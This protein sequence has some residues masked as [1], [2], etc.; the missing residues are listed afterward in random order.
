MKRFIEGEDRSQVT[1]LPECLDDYIGEDNPVRVI[2]AFVDEL[3]LQTLGFEGAEPAA[4][5]RP[6]YHPAVLLKIY[7][8]GYLNRIQSSR[9][10]EREAQRNV[11]LMWL[12]GRLAPDFKTIADFRH[13][14]GKGIRNVC[15]RFVELCR[16]LKLF[17]QAVVAVDGSKFKAV[18]TR[19]RNF[20]PGKIKKRQ[21]Q[22]EESIKRYLD[23][24][25]T[26]DRTLPPAEFQAKAQHLKDKLRTM[27]DQMR[28][29]QRIEQRLKG[30]PEGQLSLTDPD[31]RSMAT[32]GKGSGIVGYNVQVAVDAKH[33]LIVTHEVTN[34][35]HDRAQLA[36]MTIAAR[37]AMGKN[38]LQAVADRGYYSG[39]QI[40]AC[41][42][43][44]IA[45]ILPKSMTSNAKAEGRFDKGDFIYIA[46]DDEY[47]CP[48]GQRAIYRFTREE[49]G[50][51]LRRYWSSACPQ[52]PMKAQCTPS[53]YR[54][55]SRWEHEAVLEAVQRRLDKH[56]DAMM[57]RRRTV[58]HVFG[59][60]K[61]W[62]GSTHFLTRT[63][64]N[65]GT[66]M[67]L[68]VLAYNLKRVINILGIAKTM[69]AIRL[70][71]A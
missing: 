13:D 6:S 70:V 4:T 7:V 38:K 23:A 61:H 8:Y 55:I 41:H 11:E 53:D 59:T 5:G 51:Q 62:M 29:M 64:P 48:A 35:G 50:L 45:A 49:N 66:E 30:E 12:T 37:E 24:L 60:L 2:D 43:A 57:L 16:E 28:R 56:P 40:K 19:D 32:S 68:H 3:D 20:T 71:G 17:T 31:A 9:R 1:L 42:D 47:Q 44:G 34:E 52:C 25:D 15:R 26:A 46:K 69:K 21:E 58:E 14:N 65:V 33:H 54:R 36:P 18:N 63:L 22:I 67:S 39:P 10:L 27:R